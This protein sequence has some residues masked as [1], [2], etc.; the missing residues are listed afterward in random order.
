MMTLNRRR[1]LRAECR[2]TWGMIFWVETGD[3]GTSCL[4]RSWSRRSVSSL[5]TFSVSTV[6][7]HKGV[8]EGSIDLHS[9]SIKLFCS[10]NQ[11]QLGN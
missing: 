8:I 6:K 3:A 2:C 11:S 1:C 7:F 10:N 4:A 9:H 5:M